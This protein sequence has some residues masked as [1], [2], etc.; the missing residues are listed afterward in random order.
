MVCPAERCMDV[1]S[2][3]VISCGWTPL[4]V[5]QTHCV[6]AAVPVRVW[7]VPVADAHAAFVLALGCGGSKGDCCSSGLAS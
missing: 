2:L 6:R 1:A 7:L 3:S 5:A 4:P